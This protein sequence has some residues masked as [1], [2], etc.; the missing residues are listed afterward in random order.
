MID[1]I[2]IFSL[3]VNRL[4]TQTEERFVYDAYFYAE[5]RVSIWQVKHELEDLH[6]ENKISNVVEEYCFAVLSNKA[7]PLT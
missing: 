3:A 6:F 1:N 2:D 5:E 7:K 4:K